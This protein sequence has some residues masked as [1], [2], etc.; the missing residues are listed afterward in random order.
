MSARLYTSLIKA[1]YSAALMLT[2]TP[3]M[4]P[5]LTELRRFSAP[6]QFVKPLTLET[7]AHVGESGGSSRSRTLP[8]MSSAS[9]LASGLSLPKI[10]RE[11]VPSARPRSARWAVL[12]HVGRRSRAAARRA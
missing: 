1:G 2:A 12:G 9:G 4:P 7:L 3:V 5:S 11:A 10:S 6:Y 8:V